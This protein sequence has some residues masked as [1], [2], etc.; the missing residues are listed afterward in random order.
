MNEMQTE[1]LKELQELEIRKATAEAELAELQLARAR[2]DD[3]Q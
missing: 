2:E 1:H 3:F